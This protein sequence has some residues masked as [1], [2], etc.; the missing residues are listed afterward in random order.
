MFNDIIKSYYFTQSVPIT[1]ISF[2][3]VINKLEKKFLLLGETTGEILL[4]API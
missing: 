3:H 2:V 4:N 1:D